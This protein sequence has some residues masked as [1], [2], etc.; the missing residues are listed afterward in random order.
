MAILGQLEPTGVNWSQLGQTGASQG[1]PGLNGGGDPKS[2]P[3]YSNF[4]R[5]EEI[6]KI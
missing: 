3:S 4:P 2:C 6:L 1:Q 5:Q